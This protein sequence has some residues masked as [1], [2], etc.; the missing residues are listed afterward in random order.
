MSF[1]FNIASQMP[2][3]GAVLLQEI[4]RSDVEI[5]DEETDEDG[6]LTFACLEYP[7]KST[8]GVTVSTHSKHGI[9]IGINAFATE[10][11]AQ[12]CLDTTCAVAR[13]TKEQI[14]AESGEIATDKD[15]MDALPVNWVGQRVKEGE[16]LVQMARE[17]MDEPLTVIGSRHP[18]TVT[19]D[20]IDARGTGLND[21]ALLTVLQE[22][23]IELQDLARSGE[24]F[25]PTILEIADAAE[26]TVQSA[27]L[28]Q[29]DL[30]MIAQ[31]TDIALL[32]REDEESSYPLDM[33]HLKSL[34]QERRW[35]YFDAAHFEIP[36]LDASDYERLIKVAISETDQPTKT[37]TKRSKP[38]FLKRIFGKE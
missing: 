17:E 15:L 16:V 5:A 23:C 27:F 22:N 14:Q 4:G 34:A 19:R 25:V 1:Y 33:R 2:I 21:A 30:R 12:L 35:T 8:C 20:Y 7:G 11:D 9:E 37:A 10:D 29:C 32:Y 24:I 13:V 26:D 3:S 18:Y 38:G 6:N 31:N 36:G 28:L